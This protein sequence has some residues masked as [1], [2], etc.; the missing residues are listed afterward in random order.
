M[1]HHPLRPRQSVPHTWSVAPEPPEGGESRGWVRGLRH[2]GMPPG[3]GGPVWWSAPLAANAAVLACEEV[4]IRVHLP[5][6]AAGTGCQVW[7]DGDLLAD[8][9]YRLDPVVVSVSRQRLLPGPA[10]P[11]N[12]VLRVDAAPLSEEA[13]PS[14]LLEG[15]RRRGVEAVRLGSCWEDGTVEASF[16][17]DPTFGPGP[18]SVRYCLE[19]EAGDM[20][21]LRGSAPVGLDGR[22]RLRA[23]GCARWSTT[24]PQRYRGTF[25][26]TNAAGQE[27]VVNATLGLRALRLE[28]DGIVLN[29]ERVPL[30]AVVPTDLQVTEQTLADE[31][32]SFR[33]AGFNAL[34][35]RGSGP[36]CAWA[37]AAEREG[38]MSLVEPD[39]EIEEKAVEALMQIG[40]VIGC[41]LGASRRTDPGFAA[42]A[43][44][45]RATGR[46]IFTMAEEGR[47]DSAGELESDVH[48][49]DLALPG[50]PMGRLARQHTEQICFEEP[51]LVRILPPP[52]RAMIDGA[53]S[54]DLT[55]FEALGF[56]GGADALLGLRRDGIEQ[57]REAVAQMV[58][59]LRNNRQ[60]CGYV[61][62]L[63][64]CAEEEGRAWQI[65]AGRV[66]GEQAGSVPPRV[67]LGREGE[68]L[69]IR[70]APSDEEEG[71]GWWARLSSVARQSAIW[72]GRLG[73]ESS[74]GQRGA[75]V[76]VRDVEPGRYSLE[77]GPEDAGGERI[78][79]P[80]HIVAQPVGRVDC[81]PVVCAQPSV[82][83]GLGLG[84]NRAGQGPCAVRQVL[85]LGN[86]LLEHD[87]SMLASTLSLAE[88]GGAVVLLGAPPG[89]MSLLRRIGVVG[90]EVEQIDLRVHERVIHFLRNARLAE[91]LPRPCGKETQFWAGFLP[92]AAFAPHGGTVHAGAYLPGEPTPWVATIL[93]L[94]CGRGRLVLSTF[95]WQR[96]LV[97]HPVA[98][99]LLDRLLGFYFEIDASIGSNPEREKE[100]QELLE[101]ERARMRGWS[102]L[103][104]LEAQ[105]KGYRSWA[106]LQNAAALEGTDRV[107]RPEGAGGRV[108]RWRQYYADR[109]EGLVVLDSLGGP[110]PDL[111]AI[112]VGTLDATGDRPVRVRLSTPHPFRLRV[113][114]EVVVEHPGGFDASLRLPCRPGPNR[115]VMTLVAGGL[116]CESGC[117]AYWFRFVVLD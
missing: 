93:E 65:V 13:C 112:A 25:V 107:A 7:Y 97:R 24:L 34:W 51:T 114:G 60:L 31:A 20:D 56:P 91:G 12:L 36:L 21:S 79:R 64:G 10:G 46:L 17:M 37:R 100:L 59:A 43:E 26:C 16:L 74:T 54:G 89:T 14:V 95:P 57:S 48:T 84:R 45:V 71:A 81:V 70:Q 113:N 28:A 80:V 110:R 99:L 23:G 101:T 47:G 90:Q 82:A 62:D 2:E 32:A 8:V 105:Q 69:R 108:A 39:S 52:M 115:V 111:Y 55:G 30:R 44:R 86:S 41:A 87:A 72:Q 117:S 83:A 92:G 106:T 58:E 109:A 42:L 35:L 27:D 68:D 15:I 77:L 9:I 53:A 18:W 61:I 116:E 4:D 22:A 98:D 3:W 78:E 104:P 76:P 73:V 102:V 33:C 103:H 63:S 38:L 19:P 11:G 40:G 94:A 85:T 49:R 96:G 29:G 75:V 88:A 1:L 66:H 50:V 6:V 67:L 5:G